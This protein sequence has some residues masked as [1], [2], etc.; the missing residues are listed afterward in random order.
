MGSSQSSREI[1]QGFSIANKGLELGLLRNG[2]HFRYK[3]PF[4][5]HGDSMC[6]LHS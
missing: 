6:G 1:R 3:C 4:Q 2:G 5:G